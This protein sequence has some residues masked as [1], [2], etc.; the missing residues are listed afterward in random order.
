MAIVFPGAQTCYVNA[1]R[2]TATPSRFIMRFKLSLNTP[3]L[4]SDLALSIPQQGKRRKPPP[5]ENVD[6]QT[7]SAMYGGKRKMQDVKSYNT[8]MADQ[9]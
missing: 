3:R 5:R 7:V 2:R 1:A 6:K 4:I 9:K 8:T